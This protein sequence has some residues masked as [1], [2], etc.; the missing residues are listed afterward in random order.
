M[1]LKQGSDPWI[2]KKIL[3]ISRC[4]LVAVGGGACVSIFLNIEIL[5][6]SAPSLLQTILH[7]RLKNR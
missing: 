4:H 6:S 7:K 1:I 3:Q 2:L 5:S